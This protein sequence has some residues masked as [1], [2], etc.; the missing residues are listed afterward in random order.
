MGN[1]TS[2]KTGLEKANKGGGILIGII[3]LLVLL[4]AKSFLWGIIIIAVG[5]FAFI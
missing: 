1:V 2:V 3:G 5:V 4:G